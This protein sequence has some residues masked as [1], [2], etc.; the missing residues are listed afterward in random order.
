MRRLAH[1]DADSCNQQKKEEGDLRGQLV[2]SDQ[3]FHLFGIVELSK[4][5]R[6]TTQLSVLQAITAQKAIPKLSD[7]VI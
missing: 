1:T 7:V 2:R 3:A 4:R 5:R 6:Y